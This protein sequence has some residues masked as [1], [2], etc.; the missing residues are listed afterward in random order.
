MKQTDKQIDGQLTQLAECYRHMVEV[1]GSSPPL[2]TNQ[3]RHSFPSGREKAV[4]F[5]FMCE[6]VI[7]WSGNLRHHTDKQKYV[8]QL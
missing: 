8:E 6:T 3:K 1:E 4:S 2:P 7:M 5:S